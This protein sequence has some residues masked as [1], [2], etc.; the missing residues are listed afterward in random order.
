[1]KEGHIP[2]D[3]AQ[4]AKKMEYMTFLVVA[5]DAERQWVHHTVY[6]N[7]PGHHATNVHVLGGCDQPKGL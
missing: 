6:K 2:K 3:V 4:R 5:E 1:M 7:V